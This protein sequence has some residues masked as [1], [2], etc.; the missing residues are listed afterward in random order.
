MLYHHKRGKP[1]HNQM[2]QDTERCTGFTHRRASHRL[3]TDKY[4]IY[5]L[6]DTSEM[7]TE[8]IA[9]MKLTSY[10]SERVK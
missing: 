1:T 6:Q 4:F 8:M 10:C 9:H 2:G 3:C 5:V 7:E